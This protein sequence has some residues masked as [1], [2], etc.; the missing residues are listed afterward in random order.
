MKPISTT[1][2]P[3]SWNS[4]RAEKINDVRA[5]RLLAVADT[6]VRK[7][8]WILGGDGWGYDIGFGG[9][10]P[11]PGQRT[12][13]QVLLMDTESIP[14][15][16]ANARNRPLA[17]RGEIASAANV[18]PKGLGDDRDEL[19]HDLRCSVAMGAKTSTP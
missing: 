1:R 8:V 2:G 7:S 4:N 9:L 18:R 10:D 19:W 3:A 14:T 16:V 12:Q 6:L 15:R 17:V 11:R 5:R 13:R